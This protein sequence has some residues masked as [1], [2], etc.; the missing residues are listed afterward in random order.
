ML[1]KLQKKKLQLDQHRPL[2]KALVKNLA[3]WFDV[4]LTYA[5]NAI[6]GNTLSR[7]ETAIV[8]DKG[9]TIGGKSLNEHLEVTS[10]KQALIFMRGLVDQ[11]TITQTELLDLNRFIL[12]T[13]QP[14][15]A[16]RYRNVMVRIS[17]STTVLPNAKKVPTL[18]EDFFVWLKNSN[19]HPVEKAALAHYKLVTIHPFID[20]NGR[21]ARL[22]MNLLLLQAGYPIA[23]ISPKHRLIYL[24]A[25]ERAQTGGSLESFM[26]LLYKAVDKSLDIYLKAISGEVVLEPVTHIPKNLLKIGEVAKKASETVPTIRFW[27]KEGLIQPANHTESGYFLYNEKVF[28]VIDKIREMQRKRLSIKEIKELI[29]KENS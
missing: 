9:I 10:H 15:D 14:D 24:S 3:H 6:E 12:R 25:L 28:P 29:K 22:L 7:R 18:M 1:D 5:S 27:T 11:K 2:S 4:E 20:G 23:I 26:Q 8:F 19:D 13:I 17:G 21:T 16:G